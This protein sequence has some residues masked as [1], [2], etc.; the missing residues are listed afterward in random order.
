MHFNRNCMSN[1]ITTKKA[2]ALSSAFSKFTFYQTLQDKTYLKHW[3][4]L[5]NDA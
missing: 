4:C 1:M 2:S 5:A 3:R